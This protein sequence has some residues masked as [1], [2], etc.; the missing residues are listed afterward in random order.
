MRTA[1]LI[2]A[3]FA[4]ATAAVAQ[5]PR[6]LTNA[7]VIA[8]QKAGLAPAV[9][10]AKIQASPA[11]FDTSTKA[12]AQLHA[13]GV[14][15]SVILA[16]IEKPVA[17]PAPTLAA[18]ATAP[19]NGEPLLYVS[20]FRADCPWPYQ[21]AQL[22]QQTVA[23]LQ[24]KDGLRFNVLAAPVPGPAPQSGVYQLN[25]EVLAWHAGN[26]AV[27]LMVGMGAGRETAKIRYWLTG[28]DGR[29]LFQHTD[30]IRAAYWGNAYAGSSSQLAQPF[31]NKIAARL[32]KLKLKPKR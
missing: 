26:R 14:P 7:D 30:T 19:A 12:L 6:R 16:M 17:P 31:A 9:I 4:I 2:F 10:L 21:P 8:L 29:R 23:E 22:Q 18:R 1:L 25:G 3:A 5:A 27:R 20:A 24:L 32:R 13:D 28:P 15:Q 11:A